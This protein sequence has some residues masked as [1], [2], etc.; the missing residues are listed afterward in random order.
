MNC[1]GFL[2]NGGLEVTS[3]RVVSY[4]GGVAITLVAHATETGIH[5]SSK[6]RLDLG[7]FV[8]PIILDLYMLAFTM[9]MYLQ[10]SNYIVC[11]YYCIWCIHRN[12]LS[13]FI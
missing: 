11:I 6:C 7:T 8:S 10:V 2:R 9:Y 13:A 4:I 5:I 12:K 1:Q 3:D